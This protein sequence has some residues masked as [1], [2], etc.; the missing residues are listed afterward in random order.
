MLRLVLNIPHSSAECPA[1]YEDPAKL[2]N[3]IATWTDFYTD[4]LFGIYEDYLPIR[5]VIYGK[6]RFYCDCERLFNDPMEL[7]GEGFYYT[8]FKGNERQ[9][10]EDELSKVLLDY[11]KH[12]RR[13]G[14]TITDGTLL[15]DC[16]SFPSD[17]A[18]DIDICIGYNEG[19]ANAPS[20][21]IIGLTEQFFMARGYT[22]ARNKPYSNSITPLATVPY[23]SM[24]IELNKNLY[25]NADGSKG[26]GFGILQ[27]QINDFYRFLLHDCRKTEKSLSKR[28]SYDNYIIKNRCLIPVIRERM[29]QRYGKS[30]CDE[31]AE[32]LLRAC[33][34]YEFYEV[35][36]GRWY[37]IAK[38]QA[39]H[40]FAIKYM[41]SNLFFETR[42]TLIADVLE[43]VEAA[44]IQSTLED[45]C[46][47]YY[48][49]YKNRW[50]SR[51]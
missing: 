29:S 28:P 16:H 45:E 18:P 4:E 20:E 26:R 13:L 11:Y 34:K 35:R 21:D 12:Q 39:I 43:Q 33:L 9:T 22:V 15:I 51:F 36:K 5:K 23:H 25:L 19:E 47:Q 24:M 31:W 48:V 27:G 30:F 2:L 40:N 32:E 14:A 46:R 3:D 50:R 10:S 44:G 7:K 6:S 41:P 49:W 37:Q 42:D 8:N 1:E 38:A 17:L